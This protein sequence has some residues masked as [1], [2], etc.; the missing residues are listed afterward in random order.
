VNLR[1]WYGQ[2]NAGRMTLAN[3]VIA[4][5]KTALEVI[6]EVLAYRARS[7]SAPPAA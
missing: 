2:V 7:R 3:A 5:R 1:L 6:P 4:R